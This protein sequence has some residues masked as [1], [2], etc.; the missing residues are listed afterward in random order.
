[1]VEKNIEPLL[2]SELNAKGSIE[3][4]AE[5]SSRLSIEH[6]E[7]VGL[8]KSLAMDEY[9]ILTQLEK[10]QWILTKEGLEYVSLG[11]PEYRLFSVISD[12][13]MLKD[14]IIVNFS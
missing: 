2:L 1:M 12:K 10:K 4:S 11:T 14:E 5:Y 6:T 7:L 13:G 8:L 9:V 3:D